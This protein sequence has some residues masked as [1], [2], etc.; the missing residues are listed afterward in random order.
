MRCEKMNHID[1]KV[2]IAQRVISE[3]K[4]GQ[5]INLGVGIPTIIPDLLKSNYSF[6][7]H[8]E[9]GLLGVGP[10]P[11]K[12]EEDW[13]NLN[14][15]KKPITELK[16][17]AFFDSVESFAM[18]RGCHIDVAVLGALQVDENGQIANWVIPN[19]PILGVGGAMDLISGAKKVIIALTHLSKDGRPK[20]VER[21]KLPRSGDRPADLIIT[22]LA[23]FRRDGPTLVLEEMSDFVTLD[24]LRDMTE[25]KFSVAKN[26]LKYERISKEG[27]VFD[28]IQDDFD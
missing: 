14:A 1:K 4:N 10:S 21:L 8:T 25:A 26:L 13:D 18:I 7:F 12:G 27:M 2:R 28:K 23:V 15:S 5:I 17:S 6:Y 24:E 9:N 22:D 11:R 16:G 20:I 19:K 3:F